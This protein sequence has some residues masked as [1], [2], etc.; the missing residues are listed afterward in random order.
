MKEALNYLEMYPDMV[1]KVIHLRVTSLNEEKEIKKNY[2][3]ATRRINLIKESYFI[4]DRSSPVKQS[5]I[6][7]INA[8]L[9]AI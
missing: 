9:Q 6:S 2:F 5:F 3:D 4:Y 1:S 7:E 8:V